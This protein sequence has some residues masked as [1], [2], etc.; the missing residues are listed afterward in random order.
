M[1]PFLLCQEAPFGAPKPRDF[2]TTRRLLR[3]RF[4]GAEIADEHSVRWDAVK[5]APPLNR[6][7]YLGLKTYW[8]LRVWSLLYLQFWAETFLDSALLSPI[9]S[10]YHGGHPL[11]DPDGR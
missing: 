3:A 11:S 7:L 9:G 6:M 10:G 8:A 1:V 5:N 4:D 2:C